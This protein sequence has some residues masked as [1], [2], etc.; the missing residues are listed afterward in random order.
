ML[1]EPETSLHPDLLPPLAHLIA[2][3]AARSQVV[4]VSHSSTLAAA[5]GAASGA[6]RVVLGKDLGETIMRDHDP[7]PWTWSAR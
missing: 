7:P 4:V 6:G 1:I 2:T 3:A 5:L